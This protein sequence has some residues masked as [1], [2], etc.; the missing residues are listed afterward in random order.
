M[1]RNRK[2]PFAIWETTKANGI[3]ERYIRMGNSQML[4]SSMI[5][6]TH[7]AVRVI[8]LHETGKRW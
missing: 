2:T 5:G 7:S 3:E 4:H 6:L 8:Y 1:P